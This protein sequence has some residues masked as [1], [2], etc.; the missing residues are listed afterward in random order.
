VLAMSAI[1]WATKYAEMDKRLILKYEHLPRG[2]QIGK[3]AQIEK[4]EPKAS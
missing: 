3:R 4:A 2:E 1:D